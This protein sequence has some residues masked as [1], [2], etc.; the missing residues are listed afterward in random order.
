M[1]IPMPLH[2]LSMPSYMDSLDL[3]DILDYEDY[4]ITSSVEDIPGMEEVPY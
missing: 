4:M 2:E 3:S 1:S